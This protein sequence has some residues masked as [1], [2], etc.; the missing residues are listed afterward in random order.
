LII[1]IGYPVM[2]GRFLKVPFSSQ[3][4]GA[5][6]PVFV[7]VLLF[8]VTCALSEWIVTSSWHGLGGWIQFALYCAVTFA[9]IL[10]LAFYAG[11]S[12]GQRRQILRRVRVVLSR[13]SE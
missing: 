12:D 4:K 6:R 1:S 2:I 7:T 5:L 10:A 11:L 3:V 8:G 13:S 9:I